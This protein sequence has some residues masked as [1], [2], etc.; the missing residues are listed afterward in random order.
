[1]LGLTEKEESSAPGLRIRSERGTSQ[2][3]HY[4]GGKREP[5]AG[6]QREAGSAGA[7]GAASGRIGCAGQ[8]DA[9]L[10]RGGRV[11]HRGDRG[12]YEVEWQ[13]GEGET[14]SCPAAGGKPGK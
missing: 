1:M 3:G 5:R 13:H 2:T 14:F 8:V 4:F 12:S 6:H 7:R 11:F 10:E 9:D